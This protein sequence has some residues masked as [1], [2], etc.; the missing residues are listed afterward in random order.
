MP[1][2][3]GALGFFEQRHPEEPQQE[4]EQEAHQKNKIIIQDE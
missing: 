1:N 2:F 4:K 3:D